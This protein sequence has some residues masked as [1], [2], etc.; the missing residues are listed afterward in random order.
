MAGQKR[1]GVLDERFCIGA[2]GLGSPIV[3]Y[4]LPPESVSS[5]ADFDRSRSSSNLQRWILGSMGQKM[6][7]VGLRLNPRETIKSIN[8]NTDAGFA[9]K[10]RLTSEN[11]AC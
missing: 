5:I 2:G 9:Y 10:V 8:P 6:R 1:F 3:S 4:L 11:A 7:V